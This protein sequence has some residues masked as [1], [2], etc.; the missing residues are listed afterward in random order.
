MNEDI[1]GSIAFSVM[2]AIVIFLIIYYINDN[3]KYLR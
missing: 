1:L 3:K 2:C